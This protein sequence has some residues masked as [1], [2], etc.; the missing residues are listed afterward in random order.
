MIKLIATDVDGTLVRDAAPSIYPE[1]I[2]MIKKLREHDIIFCIA[3]GR[4]YSSMEKMFKEVKDDLIFI[5][6]NGAHVK[7]R[8][9][10]LNV[11]KMKPEHLKELMEE[12]RGYQKEGCEII[13]EGPGMTYTES[14]N[15]DFI[16]FIETQYRCDYKQVDDVLTEGKDIVKASIFRRPSIRDI[17]EGKLIPK[18]KDRLKATMAGEDWVDFM[19]PSVDKGNALKFIQD[20]FGI[21]PEETMVFGD[22]NNDIGM[23]KR[24]V[25]SYA[26][27]TAPEVVKASANHIAP[28]WREKGVY[29]VLEGL[30]AEIE[31]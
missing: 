4:Q 15:P 21:K 30:L 29:Q 31:Q 27:E 9:N 3:S 8:G 24:A 17:G 26:V 6:D 16:E 13:C 7:C 2:E 12:L 25:E 22:N 23:L 19:D 11:T 20:F 28:S 10:D 18:W 1:M 14:K 5:A